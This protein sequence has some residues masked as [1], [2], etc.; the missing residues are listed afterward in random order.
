MKRLT[1]KKGYLFYALLLIMAIFSM[2]VS[3]IGYDSEYQLAMG[4]RLLK[5]DKMILEMWEPH[6]TSAFLCAFLMKLYLMITNT[7]TGIVLYTQIVGLFI[8]IAIGWFLYKTIRTVTGEK[9][10]T[11]AGILYLLISPKD[12]LTPDFSNMMLWTSSLLFLTIIKYLDTK[13]ISYLIL[14]AIWLCLG[15]LSYPSFIISYFAMLLILQKYSDTTRRDILLFTGVCA[16]IGGIYAGYFLITIGPEHILNC[17]GKALSIEPSHTISTMDKISIHILNMLKIAAMLAGVGL[18]AFFITFLN[19]LIRSKK[20]GNTQ[21]FFKEKWLVTS[22]Y[23]LLIFFLI[24]ILSAE[25]RG[26]IGIPL[27][28]IMAIGFANKNLLNYEEKRLY[29]ISLWISVMCLFATLILSDH[30]FLQGIT[31]MVLGTCT[32]VIPLWHLIKKELTTTKWLKYGIHIFILLLIFRCLYIHVPMFGRGQICS[33]ASDMGLVRSGPAAGIITDESG[34]ARQRDSMAEWKNHIQDGD[35]I[36]IVGE[37]LDTLGYL[38]DDVEIGAPSVMSTP[39]YNKA[40]EYYWEL[41]PEKY[42]EVVIVASSFGELEWTL[43]G[44]EWLM[45]W[46]EEYDADKVVDGNYWRYYIKRR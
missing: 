23:V 11:M 12:I 25:N 39:T 37:P 20:Q 27:L 2:V 3:N 15:V 22:W 18:I 8:R 42:P 13:R 36:W 38:Y 9:P 35:T 21:K 40:L 10:A 14:S 16:L 46:L 34:A 31:Y 24:N 19:Q 44:N 33:I 45:D 5:G 4:Y 30:A 41:N 32:S 43:L 29:Y 1:N 17:V 7:T 6:Q 26:G 28:F